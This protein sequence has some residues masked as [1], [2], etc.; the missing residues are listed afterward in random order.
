MSI[1]DKHQTNTIILFSLI[2]VKYI[3]RLDGDIVDGHLDDFLGEGE[4]EQY[5]IKMAS[6]T[7][8]TLVQHSPLSRAIV[9]YL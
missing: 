6:E 4:L 3:S 7:L 5:K 9:T 2:Y 1:R 8:L